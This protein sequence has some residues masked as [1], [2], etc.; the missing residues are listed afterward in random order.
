MKGLMILDPEA[1]GGRRPL[2]RG[3]VVNGQVLKSLA[4]KRLVNNLVRQQLRWAE[5]ERWEA[6][7]VERQMASASPLT[8]A[9][10]RML[11]RLKTDVTK[12]ARN[13]KAA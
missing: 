4:M 3:V 8:V 1:P 6:A 13:A 12:A 5:R 11:R 2:P 9:Q 7:W 10:T